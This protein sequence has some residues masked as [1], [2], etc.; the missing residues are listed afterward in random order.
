MKFQ[1]V[2]ICAAILFS[3]ATTSSAQTSQAD[4]ADVHGSETLKV[5]GVGAQI[6]EC[7][8]VAQGRLEWVFRDPAAALIK[9]GKTLG[10]HYAGP[11]WRM[12][13]G[14]SIKGVVVKQAQGTTSADIPWLELKAVDHLGKG[15]LSNVTS[16]RRI[17]TEGGQISGPCT[18]EGSFT[19]ASYEAEYIFIKS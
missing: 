17:R 6:Y 3:H 12:N 8:K 19:S 2:L 18:S 5:Q 13:D 15:F 14:S 11:T 10:E 1:T 9:D 7:K 4:L 16:V